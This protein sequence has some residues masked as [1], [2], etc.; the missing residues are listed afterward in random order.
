MS[1]TSMEIPEL[2]LIA[3][4]G[5]WLITQL[6]TVV[7]G[8]RIITKATKTANDQKHEIVAHFDSKLDA[9][10]TSVNELRSEVKA[11]IT[12]TS[13]PLQNVTSRL[14]SFQEAYNK[15]MVNLNDRLEQ[16]P[17]YVSE[18]VKAVINGMKGWDVKET[19]MMLDQAIKESGLDEAM[20]VGD[21]Y[22]S[23]DPRQMQVSAL[24]RLNAITMSEEEV[25]KHPIK[26]WLL[27][28]A[29]AQAAQ[30]VGMLDMGRSLGTSGA[31]VV[32]SEYRS[33]GT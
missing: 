17:A 7:V 8:K 3:V 33:L 6:F 21:A 20:S 18:Q 1:L 4:L 24:A 27:E 32:K 19:Q 13:S 10:D 30:Y 15:S 26:A 31:T 12:K 22:M 25:A 5:A 14:D 23:G 9:Y 16:M 2:T 29:K 28:L 11:S